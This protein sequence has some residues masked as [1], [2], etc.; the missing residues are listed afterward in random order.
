MSEKLYDDEI[1]PKLKELSEVCQ[2]A[3]VPFLAL[4]EYE[5]GE[6]GRTEY[7]PDSASLQMHI[8]SFAARCDGDVDALVIAIARFCKR[9]GI[10]VSGS[11]VL[12]R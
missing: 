2:R 11:I 8:A 7:A 1:A 10:D 6:H 12:T 3:G 9:K 5:P 4:V